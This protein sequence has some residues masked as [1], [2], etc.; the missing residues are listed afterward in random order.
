M[1]IIEKFPYAIVI[2]FER[3]CGPLDQ[4]KMQGVSYEWANVLCDELGLPI[5]KDPSD[6]TSE[7]FMESLSGPQSLSNAGVT[8]EEILGATLSAALLANDQLTDERNAA[9]D[10]ETATAADLEAANQSIAQ[11][12]AQV[13]SQAA[14]I[15][16][17]TSEIKQLSA[18]LT[19]LE[20]KAAQVPV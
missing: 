4:H 2:R 19:E 17:Q 14:Q 16:G 10:E 1:Q 5:K 13:A 3:P 18:K 12:E 15:M 11:L 7:N 6:P 8:F 20:A 9:R